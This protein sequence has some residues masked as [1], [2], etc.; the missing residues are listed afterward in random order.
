MY[1]QA[2][3]VADEFFSFVIGARD[4]A[5]R[6]R[7]CVGVFRAQSRLQPPCT[8]TQQVRASIT[9]GRGRELL[10]RGGPRKHALINLRQGAGCGASMTSGEVSK[11]SS[12]EEA[13]ENCA[14]GTTVRASPFIFQFKCDLSWFSISEYA[15]PP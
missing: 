4:A 7:A 12:R 6:R 11:S 9:F 15:P 1:I 3:S 10:T 2:E 5:A 14:A 13:H 8:K